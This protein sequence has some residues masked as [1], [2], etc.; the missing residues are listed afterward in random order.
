MLKNSPFMGAG[1]ITLKNDCCI[2]PVGK[3][4][5]ATK[6][7]ELPQLINIITG[8]LSFIGPRP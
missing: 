3:F 7:N 2:L 8:E 5:W 4:L 6:I 1:T